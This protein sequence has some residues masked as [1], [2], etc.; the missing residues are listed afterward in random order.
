MPL[1]IKHK[2]HTCVFYNILMKKT[3]YDLTHFEMYIECSYLFYIVVGRL[4]RY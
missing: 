4:C 2:K 1:K 3:S